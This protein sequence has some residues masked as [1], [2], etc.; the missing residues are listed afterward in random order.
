MSPYEF[1]CDLAASHEN[2]G[3]YLHASWAWLEA[4]FHAP[5]NEEQLQ[6]YKFADMNEDQVS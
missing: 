4:G 3:K 5:D 6:C 2:R 1:Y